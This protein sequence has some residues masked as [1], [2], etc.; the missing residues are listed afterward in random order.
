MIR[1]GTVPRKFFNR[2]DDLRHIRQLRFWPLHKELK[3]K[4]E[5]SEQDATELADFLVPILDFVPDKRP[6]PAQCLNHPWLTEGPSRDLTPAA[7]STP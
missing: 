6:T 7:N 1:K 5:F 3:E 2:H 4:Y